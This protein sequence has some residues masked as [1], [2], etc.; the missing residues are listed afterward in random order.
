MVRLCNNLKFYFSHG[1]AAIILLFPGLGN[2]NNLTAQFD[3]LDQGLGR[4]IFYNPKALIV[5]I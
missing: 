5:Q 3:G 4:T 2:F 1:L